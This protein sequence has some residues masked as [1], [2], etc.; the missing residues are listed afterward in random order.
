[1]EAVRYFSYWNRL[2][3]REGLPTPLVIFKKGK[4][5]QL[6]EA[7]P[8]VNEII[9]P[10]LR[11]NACNPSVTCIRCAEKTRYHIPE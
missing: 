2:G 3:N 6:E 5:I 10:N 9:N 11:N 8:M 4:N 7:S 1:M